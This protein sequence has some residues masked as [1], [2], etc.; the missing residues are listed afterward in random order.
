MV[1]PIRLIH[2]SGTPITSPKILPCSRR[3]IS[4]QDAELIFKEP[5]ELC[6]EAHFSISA[7]LI[8]IWIVLI[9]ADV[10]INYL[11]Q[12]CPHTPMDRNQRVSRFICLTC[13]KKKID[14]W[15]MR[16][17]TYKAQS[18]RECKGSKCK[19]SRNFCSTLT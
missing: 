18:A 14:D 4:R 6:D 19:S 1:R 9:K 16:I 12:V 7:Q 5:N 13:N 2:S 10:S 11:S 15:C 17:K 3:S 8:R